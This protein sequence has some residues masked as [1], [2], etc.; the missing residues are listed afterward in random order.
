MEIFLNTIPDWAGKVV[1]ALLIFL[2]SW[3]LAR[4]L[5]RGLRSR[6][7]QDEIETNPAV[8]LISSTVYWGVLVLGTL[9]ALN[10]F[11]DVTAYL[12]GLGVAGFAVGF[13]LQDIMQN[14]AAGVI[15]L[16]Q[17]PFVL[18]DAVKIADQEGTV[19]GISLRTTELRTW[20]GRLMLIPNA[21][22][23]SSVIVNYSRA[24]RRRVEVPVGIGYGDDP[25]T[26]RQAMLEAVRSLPGVVAEPAPFVVFNNFGE[27]S[28]DATLYFWIDTAK[29]DIFKARDTAVVRIKAAFEAAGVE[30]PFPVRTVLLEKGD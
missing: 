27:S 26:A 28:V 4:L 30:I 16:I 14:L 19:T 20:D 21:S 3:L 7:L 8:L 10:R 24:E 13:A 25:E 11:F 22:I 17:Q 5:S 23:L 2:G 18:G 15:L 29:T 1:Q 6:L 9:T 12:A